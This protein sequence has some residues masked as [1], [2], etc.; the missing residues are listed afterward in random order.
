MLHESCDAQDMIYENE[1]KTT[2]HSMF[3]LIS[4]IESLFY[5]YF[6]HFAFVFFAIRFLYGQA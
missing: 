4:S 2:Q 3:I 6:S 1:E 5:L